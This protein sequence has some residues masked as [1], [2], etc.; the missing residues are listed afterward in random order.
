MPACPC[1]N[2]PNER[3]NPS[4]PVLNVLDKPLGPVEVDGRL[5]DRDLDS[6]NGTALSRFQTRIAPSDATFDTWH[7]RSRGRALPGRHS[8]ELQDLNQLAPGKERLQ[9]DAAKALLMT[10]GGLAERDN[11]R[12]NRRF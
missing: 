12:D 7:G 4:N 10:F 11:F 5:S 6:S 9:L 3:V 8:P 1:F 2:S